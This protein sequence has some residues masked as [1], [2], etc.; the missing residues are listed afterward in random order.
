MNIFETIYRRA[1]K[2]P[3]LIVLPEGE[4]L[5]VIEA[6]SEA[7][8]LRLARI[9]LLG[10]KEI[11]SET[12]KRNHLDI[13]GAEVIE[14]QK[15]SK[16]AD[17]IDSFLR[18]RKHKKVTPQP[19]ESLFKQNQTYFAAMMLQEGRVD[20]FV[21]G[22]YYKTSDVVRAAF[23]CIEKDSSY[24]V[25]SGSF[26]VQVKDKSYGEEGLFLFADCAIVPLPT[27]PELTDIAIASAETWVK[28]TGFKPRVAMLSFSTRGSSAH[29]CLDKVRA[30]SQL[31]KKRRP[32]LIIDGE[33]QADSAIEP[34]VSRIKAGGSP[35]AGRANILIFPNLEAGNIAYKLIQRL[36]GARVA[37][38]L[39]Q[40][41]SR[42]CSDLSR[43]ASSREIIDAIAI[44]GVRAQ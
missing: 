43:A 5:R 15:D 44:T 31:V 26:L 32:D 24:S 29:P 18:L 20:G 11:I 27:I 23:R 37:G 2:N 14:Q 16:F 25:A 28:I 35:L 7:G 13:S 40:G 33:L 38:P 8:R 22:A 12:A 39:I 9:I 3:K 19:A 36:A 30:A 6:A 17:Y 1:Q 41:L 34:E 42:P 10:R 21:S 4:Q